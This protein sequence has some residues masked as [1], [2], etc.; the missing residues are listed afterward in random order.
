[1][2]FAKS[3]ELYLCNY[4]CGNQAERL[5]K[6]KAERDAKRAL[7]PPREDGEIAAS[8]A[9]AAA[10]GS[11]SNAAAVADGDVDGDA[12]SRHSTMEKRLGT[13]CTL[14]LYSTSQHASCCTVQ[15]SMLP[16][17]SYCTRSGIAV[18]CVCATMQL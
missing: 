9:A 14:L 1:V 17:A 12:E 5:E 6:L 2:D 10:T 7:L 15:V 8:T 13:S 3:N 18:W 11:S 4:C 16:A